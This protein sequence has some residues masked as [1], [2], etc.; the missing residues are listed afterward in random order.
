MEWTPLPT[1]SKPS[2]KNHKP[3][4]DPNRHQDSAIA[5]S[6]SDFPKNITPVSQPSNRPVANRYRCRLTLSLWPFTARP[7]NNVTMPSERPVGLYVDRSVASQFPNGKFCDHLPPNQ[8]H[9][10]DLF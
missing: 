5:P 8:I 10:A 4:P 1:E 7:F 6:D 2:D 3:S 9:H